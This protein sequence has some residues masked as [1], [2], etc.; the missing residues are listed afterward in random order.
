MIALFTK[1]SGEPGPGQRADSEGVV[2]D[3]R[4]ADCEVTGPVQL[5]PVGTENR[6]WEC[7]FTYDPDNVAQLHP[8]GGPTLF[9]VDCAFTRCRFAMDV[10]AFR[11]QPLNQSGN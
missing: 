8:G 4:F 11:L 7:E 9:V 6:L 10:N 2:S 1:V 5:V 3:Q